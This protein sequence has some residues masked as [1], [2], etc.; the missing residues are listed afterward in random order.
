MLIGKRKEDVEVEEVKEGRV[1]AEDY[2]APR[3]GRPRRWRRRRTALFR[4]P[5]QR[6]RP[7]S[8]S[9]ASERAAK[10]AAATLSMG[11]Y[12]VVVH[13]AAGARAGPDQAAGPGP[14]R[15]SAASDGP[16]RRVR[17]VRHSF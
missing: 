10:A 3:L 13:E 7:S 6:Q 4:L 11:W 16:R 1:A 12:G 9:R 2:T 17:A 15:P 5:G 14:R 8:E